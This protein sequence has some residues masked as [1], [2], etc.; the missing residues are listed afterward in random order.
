M[1]S[2]CASFGVEGD[3][4]NKKLVRLELGRKI[5][6]DYPIIIEAIGKILSVE[7]IKSTITPEQIRRYILQHYTP[8]MWVDIKNNQEA[9]A[10]KLPASLGGLGL[11]AIARYFGVEGNIVTNKLKR[12]QLG[13]KIFG[14]E[15]IDNVMAKLTEQK[16]SRKV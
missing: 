13:R 12:F 14:D 11:L 6:G 16:K 7:A 8:E 4:H 15:A 9:L 5:F 2:I 3:P 1:K 10:V